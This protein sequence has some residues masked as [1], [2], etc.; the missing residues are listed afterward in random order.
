MLNNLILAGPAVEDPIC[1]EYFDKNISKKGYY[2]AIDY[3]KTH[4]HNPLV[5]K[6][7]EE[8]TDIDCN[9]LNF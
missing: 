2:K 3:S 1:Y 4:Y 8:E 7:S 9:N 5:I 6:H